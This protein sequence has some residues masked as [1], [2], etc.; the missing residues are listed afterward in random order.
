MVAVIQVIYMAVGGLPHVRGVL[1]GTALVL[2]LFHIITGP[3]GEVV[4]LAGVLRVGKLDV[5]IGAAEQAILFIGLAPWAGNAGIFSLLV[6]GTHI[7]IN[8]MALSALEI[9]KRHRP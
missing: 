8:Q 2:R 9:V 5:N 3:I 4:P 6:V 7:L 1:G